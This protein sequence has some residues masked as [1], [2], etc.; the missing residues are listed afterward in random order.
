MKFFTD[1]GSKALTP[2]AIE[3]LNN[4]IKN[5]AN[6]SERSRMDH[7]KE[8]STKISANICDLIAHE[9]SLKQKRD[10][11]F[12]LGAQKFLQDCI[13]EEL[14][15][16][17]DEDFSLVIESLKRYNKFI[18]GL[19][20]EIESS[21]THSWY[22]P[23]FPIIRF[24]V[25]ALTSG[26]ITLPDNSS[27]YFKNREEV[28]EKIAQTFKNMVTELRNAK[29]GSYCSLWGMAVCIGT[30]VALSLMITPES[31][32]N[33]LSENTEEVCKSLCNII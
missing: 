12:D 28:S 3:T 14:K 5:L 23:G 24:A 6:L 7:C 11:T 29:S 32:K 17:E 15:N 9:V 4:T 26:Y 27:V 19:P 22:I 10:F 13:L 30:T 33:L 20:K 2:I 16:M 8:I 31:V 21:S 1:L 25:Y 18:S